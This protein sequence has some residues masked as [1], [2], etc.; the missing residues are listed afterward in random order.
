M[1]LVEQPAVAGKGRPEGLRFQYGR[2]GFDEITIGTG[3]PALDWTEPK[4][5]FHNDGK[6]RFTDVGE[7]SGLVHFGMLHGTTLSDYD[8]SGNLSLFGS[9]GGFYWGSR[10]TSRLYRNLGSENMSLEIRLI[11]TCS[12][13]D[14][15]GAKVS[16]LA[17]KRRIF[18][19][20]NGGNGFGCNNSRVVHLG[21]SH[22]RQVNELQIEWPSGLRQSFENIPAGQRIEIV[23]GKGNLRSLVKFR[24][25]RVRP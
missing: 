6:G 16:A 2:D 14:A 21:L 1:A 10:E 11:G 17:G 15:I 4:P 5:L 24:E 20:V 13:R 12:N 3:N 18:K 7:S 22:E 25:G 23:E 8:D 9:F 19:W